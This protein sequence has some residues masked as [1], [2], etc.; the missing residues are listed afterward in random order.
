MAI[1]EEKKS[2]DVYDDEAALEKAFEDSEVPTWRNQLTIRSMVTSL[3]LSFVFN[4]IVC[5]LNLSTG[6]I[7]SLNVAAGLLGYAIVK[8]WAV[9]I[10]KFGLLKQPFNRQE[11]TV[12]QTCVVASSGIAFSSGTASY[13]LGMSPRTAAQAE[14]GNDPMNIKQL[15]IGWMMGFLFTV[16]FVG[17]FSIVP[18]RKVMIL[19]YKLTYPS[20][21]ATAYLI[22]S[23][24]TP[25]GAKL[26][27]KQVW[28]LFKSF[29]GSFF[30]ACFQWFFTAA[31]GC[32]FNSFPTFGLTAFKKRF[33]FDFSA[34]YV[35][36]GMICPYMVNVS[37]L[38]GAIFSWGILWPAIE[39]K[40]GDWY[41]A[42]LPASSL[43]GIQ[44]YRVF[45]AIAMMLGDGLFHVVYM[46]IVSV[47]S[48]IEQ[49]S[50]KNLLND[51]TDGQLTDFDEKRRTEYFLKDQIPNY[52]AIAGYVALASISIGVI[53]Q[54]FHQLKW[55]MI[56]V[57]Y[58]IAPVLAF[59]NAYGCGLTDWSLAS[60]YG[61]LA[62]LVFSS[63]VGLEHGGVLAGLA[64]CGV[65][66]SIVSTASD[67]MQDFK[68]GYLTLSSPRSMFFSQV[69]GTAMGCVMSPLVFWF[70]YKAYSV[71]DPEGSYPAPYALMYRGIALLGVEGFNSLPKN[72]VKLVILF[73]I[74]A[75]LVNIVTALLKK[76]ETKHEV[77]KFIPSPMCMAIPFYLG[78]YFAIDMCVG[79]LILFVWARKSK[80]G[81][82]E[83]GPAV[84]SGL[85]CG[86]SLWGIPA[87]VMALAGATP[88]MCM[89]FLSA[90]ANN[91]VDTYLAG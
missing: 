8:A 29:L 82:K 10:G 42:D 68:T 63:W 83:F 64:S 74:S 48:F 75:I 14:T 33:Y 47:K 22:N 45:L 44:G 86:D 39:S 3:L 20:G 54:I 13:L 88:P 71:G 50:D 6:V 28:V 4:V 27:K 9:M 30:W 2:D 31:D 43:H 40:K 11:N 60:N 12:I 89:K 18:L 77:Y 65:M 76:Y 53:P 16:S 80:K 21:T 32:G 73:F 37:L 61:K 79:S 49:N 41:S 38:V 67:L 36:V 81:A 19:R 69:F 78:G 23:F 46:V 15:S 59:C 85:I 66:M 52:V 91:A 51:T 84:A 87:A 72:C 57:A 90:S 17:L 26:A 35:G 24:H 55:Y 34:T 25:K 1:E 58:I 56:L 5:K 70:F 7:P 62:I